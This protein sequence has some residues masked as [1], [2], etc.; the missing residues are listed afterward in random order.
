MTPA[1]LQ[2][3]A[4]LVTMHDARTHH[5]TAMSHRPSQFDMDKVYTTLKQFVRDW[6]AEGAPE[7][8]KCKTSTPP[9][10]AWPMLHGHVTYG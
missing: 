7:R 9:P 10:S 5:R 1:L 2:H 3:F 8:D 6:S 4:V